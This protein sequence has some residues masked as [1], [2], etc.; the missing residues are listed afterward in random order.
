MAARATVLV[1]G[2]AA[3]SADGSDGGSVTNGLAGSP[4]VGMDMTYAG[5]P[6]QWAVLCPSG[7][8][9]V[10]A[11]D[12]VVL[13]AACLAAGATC[14]V[15]VSR[16]GDGLV[17]YH[18]S[19]ASSLL[20][21][22]ALGE[23][24]WAHLAGPWLKLALSDELGPDWAPEIEAGVGQLLRMRARQLAPMLDGTPV[25]FAGHGGG[26]VGIASS[27]VCSPGLTLAF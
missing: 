8:R 11:I 14:Q 15:A 22:A 9:A 19:A 1:A 17:R 27:W 2:E 7:F 3:I 4:W 13:D 21:R 10:D 12:L 23:Q 25:V 20:L 6:Q 26:E 5:S 18:V 16:A 24:G